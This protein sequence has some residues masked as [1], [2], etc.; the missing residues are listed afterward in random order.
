LSKR[1]Q[2]ELKYLGP[3]DELRDVQSK[4]TWRKGESHVVSAADAERLLAHPGHWE[5]VTAPE[6]EPEP[7]PI[8][9]ETKEA[10]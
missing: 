8:S 3:V 2:I 4:T 1:D 5:V 9:Q 6:P 10:K 7:T